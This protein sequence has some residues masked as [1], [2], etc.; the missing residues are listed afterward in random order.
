MIDSSSIRVHQTPPMAKK[1]TAIP[2]QGALA[3]RVN[4]QGPRACRCRGLP[5][6]LQ[7]SEGRAHDG[8]E[9]AD[10]FETVQAGHILLA[11]RAYDSDALRD[12]LRKG[13]AW[14]NIRLMPNRKNRPAISHWLCRQ[15]NDMNGSS[16]NS[17]TSAPSPLDSTKETITSSPR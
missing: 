8:R 7:L 15:R 5:V 17:N 16:I 2:L 3:W 9:A 13:G 11:D 1:N 6:A 12:T 14:G 4:H 10:M